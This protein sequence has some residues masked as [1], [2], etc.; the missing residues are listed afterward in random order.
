MR[1]K[2]IINMSKTFG[3]SLTTQEILLVCNKLGVRENEVGKSLKALL[4]EKES[5]KLIDK[6][7]LYGSSSLLS[8]IEIPLSLHT[9]LFR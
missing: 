9:I 3:L 7:M 1:R 4:L 5:S 6:S 2:N 8:S